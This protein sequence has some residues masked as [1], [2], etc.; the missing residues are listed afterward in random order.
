MKFSYNWLQSYFDKKIGSPEK[1]AEILTAH[2]YEVESIEEVKLPS[3]R[4]DHC[5]TIDILPNRSH[6]S[7]GHLGVARELAVLLQLPIRDVTKI[8]DFGYLDKVVTSYDKISISIV[9]TKLCRR[10]M[11]RLV[12]D[13][14]IKESP[15]WIKD[16]LAAIGQRSI[17]NIVDATNYV[18]YET[19]Q[20]VHAFDY[21]KLSGDGTK[22]ITIRMAEDG[23]TL[24]ALDGKEYKLTNHMQV[25]SDDKKALDVAG[26]KGGSN[27]QIDGNT[28][29][30]V[31][32][33]CSFDPVNIRKTSKLLGLRTD[34]SL[35]FEH[36]LT[37]DLTEVAMERLSQLVFEL[38]DGKVARDVVD[39]YPRRPRKYKIGVVTNDVNRHLGTKLREDEVIDILDRFTVAGFGWERVNPTK[40]IKQV[41]MTYLGVPYQ[42]GVSL[43]YD[44][45]RYFDCSSFT[46][47]VFAELG[48]AIPR[49]S[50][51]Q[52]FFGRPVLE[53]ELVVG[54][55]IFSRNGDENVYYE[56]Q[57]YLPG[58]RFEEGVN[59]VGI[60]IGDGMVTHASGGNK[61]V[62]VD[63]YKTSNAFKHLRGFRRIIEDEED[64]FVVTVPNERLDLRNQRGF[65]TGGNMEDMIEEIGRVYGYSNIVPKLPD[66]IV[67]LPGIYNRYYY[68]EFARSI[69]SGLG[70]SE[71]YNYTFVSK[72]D[73]NKH[74]KVKNPIADGRAY[75][76]YNL[77]QGLVDKKNWN[78]KNKDLLDSTDVR[79]F[80][81]G[82]IMN[83]AGEELHLAVALE[84]PKELS[85]FVENFWSKLGISKPEAAIEG[86]DFVEYD[87]G[88]IIEQ[89]P[90]KDSYDDLP[91]A[92]DARVFYKKFSLYPYVVRDIAVFAPAP[93][94]AE[95][96]LLII[97][98]NG[99]KLLHKIKLFDQFTKKF[100]DGSSKTSYAFRL[101][102]LAEDRTLTG[103]EIGQIMDKI[104]NA[105]NSKNE[106]K[107]R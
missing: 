47:F 26:I 77:S 103:E 61:Q 15:E 84:K 70:F 44:A 33:V 105:L 17:N 74:L 86:P 62:V 24:R 21:D 13:V 55:L 66:H 81:I 20:P 78:L 104:T 12:E 106:W 89:L 79:V 93:D 99:T 14:V 85:K 60:Y 82:N 67:G 83:K 42:Y 28:R 88:K 51:D 96:A 39:V 63:E 52:L 10:A 53:T 65:Y 19:G 100:D 8:F 16:R 87:F 76:R 25:I 73:D 45:P 107:V 64:R 71:L 18:M 91:R 23:E 1:V 92:E 40:K 94:M 59:H 7:S 54:D 5:L 2:A 98:E 68:S 32:S 97:K 4:H 34:A 101:V 49:I 48:Y 30:I 11:K 80:E 38:A 29:R 9:D 41:A 72:G 50:I 36:E 95:E 31:L 69:L 57:Q 22:N 35:R 46:T 6:D 90:K 3:G 75:L 58:K 27:S 37:P 56:S 43:T 102:F